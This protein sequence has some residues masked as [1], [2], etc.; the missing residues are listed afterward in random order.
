MDSYGKEAAFDMASAYRHLPNTTYVKDGFKEAMPYVGTHLV[1][2]LA[3]S[4]LSMQ[5]HRFPLPNNVT[6]VDIIWR[7]D[8]SNKFVLQQHLSSGASTTTVVDIPK[9]FVNTAGNVKLDPSEAILN[10]SPKPGDKILGSQVNIT[11]ND[12]QGTANFEGGVVAG[13]Q[14]DIMTGGVTSVPYIPGAITTD[15]WIYGVISTDNLDG[16][17]SRA[18]KAYVSKSFQ[19]GHGSITVQSP[20]LSYHNAVDYDVIQADASHKACL[21]L[22]VARAH[23]LRT[24]RSQNVVITLRT[25]FISNLV[26]S[27]D[28]PF[29]SAKYDILDNF[30]SEHTA[31]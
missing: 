13:M 9:T 16:L 7:D 17:L 8:G 15:T 23:G 31:F 25:L 18:S 1:G 22:R 10:F 28:I 4:T 20:C 6:G 5:T 14:H 11:L 30:R 26:S 24:Q 19:D 2:T 3:H 29:S 12:A 21:P 27:A